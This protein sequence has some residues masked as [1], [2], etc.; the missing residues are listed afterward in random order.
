VPYPVRQLNPT[1]AIHTLVATTHP[2]ATIAQ[3]SALL[4]LPVGTTHR[5]VLSLTKRRKIKR[6]PIRLGPRVTYHYYSATAFK[7]DMQRTPLE[8]P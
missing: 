8:L 3:M 6:R 4:Q 5:A 2:G 7:A 1:E